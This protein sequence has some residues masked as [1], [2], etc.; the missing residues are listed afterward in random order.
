MSRALYTNGDGIPANTSTGTFFQPR[1]TINAFVTNGDEVPMD[2]GTVKQEEKTETV[3]TTTVK[4]G[5]TVSCDPTGVTYDEFLK[6]TGN[7]DDAFGITRLSS[8]DVT[9]PEVVLDKGVLQKTTAGMQVSSFYLQAQTFK[10]KGFVILPEDGGVENNYCPKG[11]YERNWEITA[12]GADKIKEGEQE[13]CNDFTLAFN[14]SLAKF[15]DAVNAAAGKKFASD[16]GAKAY[17]EKQTKVH[18]DKWNDYFWCL[19]GK[20][21]ER[22]T[23]NW[24]LPK[25]ISPHINKTC[26]KAVIRLGSMNLAEIGKHPSEE[27]IKDCE[28]KKGK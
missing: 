2:N 9:F 19:A 3:E 15:R 10:D 27:I 8:N 26:N 7:T 25:L 17:L 1:N 18:P 22:D 23:N 21:R 11:K 24:H 13:H 20:T 12:S 4:A 16:A 28:T 6:K 14:I 5:T